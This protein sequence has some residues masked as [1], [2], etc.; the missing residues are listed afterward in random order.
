MITQSSGNA[1][2]DSAVIAAIEAAAPFPPPIG[3]SYSEFK[4]VNIF[5][6]AKELSNG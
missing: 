6:S 1:P 4:V 3:L 5:F 2:F